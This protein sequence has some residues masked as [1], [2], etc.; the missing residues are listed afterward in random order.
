M[1]RRD[2]KD[3]VVVTEGGS[4]GWVIALVV[5]AI[6]VFGGIYAYQTGAFEGGTKDV[7]VKVEVPEPPKAPEAPKV[8]G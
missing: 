3:T 6:L 7:N 8:G 2:E 1:A 4:A 5:A